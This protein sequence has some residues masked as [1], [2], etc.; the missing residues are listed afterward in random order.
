MITTQMPTFLL[1]DCILCMM[2]VIPWLLCY[3]ICNYRSEEISENGL[4]YIDRVIAN[5]NRAGLKAIVRFE[6]D[7]DG[8]ES[9]WSQSGLRLSL[10]HGTGWPGS[11]RA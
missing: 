9:R 4:K 11:E 3:S 6:Y 10:A 7:W 8:K 2:K 1:R 5:V